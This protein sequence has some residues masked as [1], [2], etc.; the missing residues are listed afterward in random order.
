MTLDQ[1]RTIRLR[2]KR[3]EGILIVTDDIE[4]AQFCHDVGLAFL[5]NNN[6][7]TENETDWSPLR[8]LEIMVVGAASHPSANI[9]QAILTSKP[10]DAEFLQTYGFFYRARIALEGV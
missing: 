6:L 7:E 4:V 8:A 3:P 2:R 5:Q 1:L 9:R 10:S